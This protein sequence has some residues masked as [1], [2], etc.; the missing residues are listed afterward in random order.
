MEVTPM[1]DDF[2]ARPRSSRHAREEA[3]RPPTTVALGKDQV[4]LIYQL[5]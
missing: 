3:L 4:S 1:V 5:G 2:D